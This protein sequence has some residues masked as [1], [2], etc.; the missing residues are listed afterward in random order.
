[1]EREERLPTALWVDAHVRKANACGQYFYVLRKGE[2]AGGLVILKIN[3]REKGVR[4][5]IQQRD[6]NGVLGWSDV[7]PEGTT[8]ESRADA[9]IARATE[10]DPDLWV[11]EFEDR[12]LKN[13]FEDSEA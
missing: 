5:L 3:G 6:L 2:Y 1:M 7:L 8:E 4:V 9:Y 11:I 10:R 13:P 12:A